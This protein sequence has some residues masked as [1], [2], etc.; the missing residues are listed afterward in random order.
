[1]TGF[2]SSRTGR[3][4]NVVCVLVGFCLLWEAAVIVFDVK[5]FLL[6]AP[7][8]VIADI[9]SQP[10]WYGMHTLETLKETVLGFALAV[11]VGLIMAIGIVFSRF[12]EQTLY[13]F[14]VAINS[15]PKVAVAPL[16][17]VWF[18]TGIE[19]KIAIAFLIAVFPIVIDT[20]LGLRSVE[21]DMLDLAKSMRGSAMQTLW[22]IRFPTALPSMFAGMKVGIS[23]A[24]IGAIVGEFVSASAGLGFVIDSAQPTFDTTRI[25]AAILLLAVV[26]T[27]L[28]YIVEL[29]EKAFIPW[30]VSRRREGVPGAGH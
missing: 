30:H 5:P 14:L 9:V 4:V 1:M 3:I 17:I 6:P 24:F 25:F 22:K 19:P 20:V 15:I 26:G 7:S 10:L 2:W 16:F 8:V 11:L 21:P 27:I 28:F 23:F 29:A 12:I 13:T 18:G